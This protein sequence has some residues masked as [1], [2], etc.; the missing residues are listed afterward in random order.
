MTRG[1][2]GQIGPFAISNYGIDDRSSNTCSDDSEE[3]DFRE[4]PCWAQRGWLFMMCPSSCLW[5][6]ILCLFPGHDCLCF[7]EN[8]YLTA[9]IPSS[10]V[11]SE[12]L[13]ALMMFSLLFLHMKIIFFLLSNFLCWIR[14]LIL[15]V[16]YKHTFNA[17]CMDVLLPAFTLYGILVNG[18]NLLL[19]YFLCHSSQVMMQMGRRFPN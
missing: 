2:A 1:G 7:Q 9:I 6:L 13:I 18:S 17:L 14:I 8:E 15:L 11:K 12:L 19:T 10:V 4:V 16:I 5:C 3:G